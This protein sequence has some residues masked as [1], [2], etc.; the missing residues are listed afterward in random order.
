MRA[1]IAATALMMAAAFADAASLGTAIITQDRVALRTSPR[2]SAKQQ[3]HLWQ[4][5]MVEIRSERL[6]YLQVYD[7]G[8]ERG[9][10]VRANQVRRLTLATEEAPELLAIIRF[11]RETPGSEALGIGLVAAFIQAAPV[12]I[13]NGDAGSE[14]L[15]AL[16][17]LADRLARRASGGANP[18]KSAEAALSA[19]L[20]VAA[21]YGVKFANYE[22][23]GRMRLCYEG[24]AF[25]RVLAMRSTPEQR[26]RAVLALTRAEC[27]NPGLRITERYQ[28]DEL[29]A[30]VLD[31]VDAAALPGYLKNRVLM[32]RASVWSAIAYQHTRKNLPSDAAANRALTELGGINKAELTDDDLAVYADAAMRASASRWAGLPVAVAAK[33]RATSIVTEA[34]EAGQT[35]VALVDAKRDIKNPLV[36]RCT[37]GI[38]W[39][40]SA[41]LN[42]EG[43]ALALA[44]QQTD[45]WRELW[46]FRKSSSDG[47]TIGVL[48]PATTTPGVGY[49]E[50]AGW[51]PG[52]KEMLVAREASGD[53]KYKR[54]FELL[55]L[56]TLTPMR[57]AG[58]PTLLGAFQRWQ[59]PAWKRQTLSLR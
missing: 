19:H 40:N 1:I 9:G 14:A 39:E 55:R 18:N 16:G 56:D 23:D 48:P 38:V 3:A 44:V 35:C 31:R 2:D 53:G 8:R 17:T 28:A 58:D 12:E 6:D 50:F 24:D 37:Y 11:V 57:Q 25:R 27:V 33:A 26:A 36:R 29:R 59:D 43:N 41:T 22:R 30:E 51:V 15:D 4:G 46:I 54:N 34:G 45:T 52:G 21:R 10:F 32:R 5:E 49:A 47:W 7:Y 42:R 13:I 20:D